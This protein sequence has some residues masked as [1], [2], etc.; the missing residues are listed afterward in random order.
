MHNYI[1]SNQLV[2][3]TSNHPIIDFKGSGHNIGVSKS[4]YLDFLTDLFRLKINDNYNLILEQITRWLKPGQFHYILSLSITI[5]SLFILNN[6]LIKIISLMAL[7]QHAL[8]LI[9]QPDS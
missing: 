1:Y 8:L 5:L 3:F 9:F 4:I 2:L 6:K 7:S